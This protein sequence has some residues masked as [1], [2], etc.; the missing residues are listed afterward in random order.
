MTE[1]PNCGK[2]R[3]QLGTHWVQSKNCD[4]PKLSDHQHEVITGILMGDGYIK[5]TSASYYL[6]VQMVTEEYL[7]FISSDVFPI[8]STSV[9]S[10]CRDIY[11]W[12]TRALPEINQYRDWYNS[13]EK[14]FPENIE[15]TPTILKN[16]YVCDGSLAKRKNTEHIRIGLTNERKN[17][18]KV[19]KYFDNIEVSITNW[20]DYN[21][22]CSAIF[23][24]EESNKLWEY[25]GEPLP[26]FE[27]KWPDRYK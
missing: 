1:C 8:L 21:S 2:D 11:T 25:M 18:E 27:Y 9:S 20:G 5:H 22:G 26:G 17:E 10:N 3:E 14:V 23:N 6:G 4:Y 16:W 12:R 19:R 13:G 15:L 24:S 7:E